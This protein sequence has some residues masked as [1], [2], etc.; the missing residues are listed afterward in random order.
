[1]IKEVLIIIECDNGNINDNSKNLIDNISNEFSDYKVNG[2]LFKNKNATI[3]NLN[4]LNLD[5]LY[6]V[7][8]VA[9]NKVNEINTISNIVK[10]NNINVVIAKGN[11]N[12]KVLLPKLSAKFTGDVIYNCSSLYVKE[13][14]LFVIKE[15]YY[16]NILST[17]KVENINFISIGISNILKC[18]VNNSRECEVLEIEEARIETSELINVIESVK[19]QNKTKDICNSDIVIG[20]GRAFTCESDLKMV[21]ELVE[22][23]R[24]S[25]RSNK[26]ISRC[27]NY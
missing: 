3:N 25:S 19:K 9:D 1:M 26:T 23:N 22:K 2:V 10:G 5:K 20:V 12:N 14:S 7:D 11:E 15:G 8:R 13:N 17:Y 16:G 27:R 21:F 6:V 4:K 24:G 18:T